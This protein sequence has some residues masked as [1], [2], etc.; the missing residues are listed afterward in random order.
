MAV[1]GVQQFLMTPR[2]SVT[3]CGRLSALG[4]R[5][6]RVFDLLKDGGGAWGLIY[7]HVFRCASRVTSTCAFA[8]M[9]VRIRNLVC[10]H[11]YIILHMWFA[12]MLRSA[13]QCTYAHSCVCSCVF[14]SRACEDSG[15]SLCT[16]LYFCSYRCP[17]YFF[18]DPGVI[19]N[20]LNISSNVL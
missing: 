14:C 4:L 9:S 11:S 6:E 17:I 18:K 20:T 15:T 12:F 5:A 8:Q 19:M 10:M 16:Q 13:Q 3:W 2:Y 1:S 7:L